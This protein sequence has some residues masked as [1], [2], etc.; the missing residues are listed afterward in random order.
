[1]RLGIL[2][3]GTIILA[4][5]LVESTRVHTL[6]SELGGVRSDQ[7]LG[8]SQV[9]Y[10]AKD[11]GMELGTTLTIGLFVVVGI[12][13][14]TALGTALSKPLWSTLGKPLGSIMGAPLGSVKTWD[15]TRKITWW[16][17]GPRAGNI[18]RQSS[19]LIT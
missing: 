1:M 19:Q 15:E 18:N 13:L 2:E 14:V 5:Y 16:N 8:Q 6:G 4:Q 12:V 11:F 7:D 9:Y 3:L 17:T 10:S